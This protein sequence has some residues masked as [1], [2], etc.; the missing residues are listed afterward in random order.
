MLALVLWVLSYLLGSIPTGYLI[1]SVTGVD[2]RRSGSGNIGATNVARTVGW[3]KGFL[4]LALDAAKGFL[5]VV[6]AVSLDLGVTVSSIAGLAAFI[7]HLYP[8]FLRFRGGKG[9]AT[10]LGVFLGTMPLAAA[11]LLVVFV[12]A[13]G[14]S[15]QV[16]LGSI[17][18]AGLSPLVSWLLGYEAPV[19]WCGLVIGAL[20]V[21]RH[22][23]NIQ[24]LMAGTEAKLGK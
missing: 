17:I 1:A 13:V 3:T 16:S 5:P 12:I 22:A 18:A 11:I 19:V 23:D 20:T 21:I 14:L 4:T 2:I 9:V 24:R 10:A 8:I 7:G 15:R 6:A